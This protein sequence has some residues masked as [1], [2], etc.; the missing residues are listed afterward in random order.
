MQAIGL[1]RAMV[2]TQIYNT[3]ARRVH[4]GTQHAL[5][6]LAM[7]LT[8]IMP[9]TSHFTQHRTVCNAGMPDCVGESVYVG[10][11][12]LGEQHAPPKLV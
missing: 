5:V 9:P 6:R 4:H 10:T 8:P 1:V 2:C 11:F 7:A 3:H 12:V